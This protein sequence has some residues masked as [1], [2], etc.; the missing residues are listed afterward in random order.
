MT[1]QV[2]VR[3]LRASQQMFNLPSDGTLR[4]AVLKALN[5]PVAVRLKELNR[6]INEFRWLYCCQRQAPVIVV[7]IPSCNLLLYEQGKQVLASRVVT[8]KKPTPTPTLCSRV[9]AVIL[10]PYWTVP[11]V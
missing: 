1:N 3:K 4:P 10:Y 6:A 2:L 9:T 11:N 7:D 5:V 8:G